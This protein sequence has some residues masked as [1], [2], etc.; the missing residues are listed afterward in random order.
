MFVRMDYL[1]AISGMDYREYLPR[2][3]ERVQELS[4]ILENSESSAL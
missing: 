1:K 4:G 3:E 2:L